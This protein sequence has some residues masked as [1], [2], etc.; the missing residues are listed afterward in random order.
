MNVNINFPKIFQIF[1]RHLVPNIGT[2]LVVGA[3]LFA[4]NVYAANMNTG[5]S[6]SMISYQGTL[7]TAS[8]MAVNTNVGLTFRMYNIQSEGSALW[9]EIHSG[10]PV[11]DGLFNV[12]L[13]S[14]TPIPASLWDNATVYLG[15]Q[16]EGDSSELLPRELV[17]AVPVAM[18]TSNITIPDNTIT[19]TKI[20]D[21]AV[22]ASKQT[23]TTVY[24]EDNEYFS[25]IG[26]PNVI[27]SNFS[28]SN[29]PAGDITVFCSFI[30][31]IPSGRTPFGT[32]ILTGSTGENYM[33]PTHQMSSGFGQYILHGRFQNFSGGNFNFQIRVSGETD[34]FEVHFGSSPAAPDDPRFGRHCTVTA[35]Q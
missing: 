28:L 20:A 32:I 10:V 31:S 22:V 26:T 3:L 30:A 29:V 33:M 4:N 7:S 34:N 5:T 24:T 35:G 12:L 13:G 6:S 9:T 8:G 15:I 2:I 25:T 19:T 11:N 16:V 17:S 18:V 23:I 14:I 1:S 27:V 21:G